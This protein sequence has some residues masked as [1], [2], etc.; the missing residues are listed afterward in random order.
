[1]SVGL[2]EAIAWSV[3]ACLAFGFQNFI[4]G[5]TNSLP[6][7]DFFRTIGVLCAGW[8]GVTPRCEWWG[9][10]VLWTK[11]RGCCSRQFSLISS[12]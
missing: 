8:M 5:Y 1:M 3:L 10:G 6:H 2:G 7:D 12:V 11:S 9:H 4:I